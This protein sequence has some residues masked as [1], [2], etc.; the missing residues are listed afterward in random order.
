MAPARSRSPER[1]RPAIWNVTMG[2]DGPGTEAIA[3][4]VEGSSMGA[5]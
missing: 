3:S 1:G 5:A 2:E 4:N